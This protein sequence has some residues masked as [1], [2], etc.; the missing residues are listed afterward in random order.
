MSKK[1]QAPMAQSQD[2]KPTNVWPIIIILAVAAIL[3][4]IL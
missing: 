4:I 2:S 1:R 3:M